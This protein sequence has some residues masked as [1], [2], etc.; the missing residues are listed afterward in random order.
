M[1]ADASPFEEKVGET[2]SRDI[3]TFEVTVE[4]KKR[5]TEKLRRINF[6]GTEQ[7][8]K[9]PYYARSAEKVVRM[10]HIT[11]RNPKKAGDR[12]KR[13]GKVLNVRKVNLEA[14]IGNIESLPLNQ[15]VNP[16]KNAIAMDEMVWDKKK[17]DRRIKIEKDKNTLD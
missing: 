6:C 14:L 17:E 5:G 16:Y 15:P 11:A 3:A 13:H 12:G 8:R 1:V 10:F 4:V 2:M 7:S 9:K